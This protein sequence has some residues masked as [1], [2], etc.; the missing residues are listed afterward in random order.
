VPVV[1][2]AQILAVLDE[3]HDPAT[4]ES[5]DAVGL[6]CGDPADDVSAILLA[7]DP[8]AA[9]AQEAQSLG[10]QL[11][12]T[13]H[14][15]LLSGVHSVATTSPKGALLHQLIRQ[16][17]ALHVAHTNADAANPGVSDALAR[18]LGL[19]DLRPLDPLPRPAMDRLG[20][21][22]PTEHAEALLDALAAAGAGALGNYDRAAW[23]VEGTGTFRPLPGAHP[24]FGQ[25]GRIERVRETR[26][27]LQLPRTARSRV[28]SALH[29][30]HPYETPA[31]DLV[32][33]VAESSMLGIGRIGRLPE[34]TTLREFVARAATALPATSW[35]VRAAGDPDRMI[36]S[37]ACCGGAGGTYID[38]ARAAGAD[39]YLTSDLR[40][41][42][43]SEAMDPTLSTATS[44][45]ALVDAAHWA[46]EA[47]WLD[48]LGA[49]LRAH[50]GTS[51]SVSV[52][53]IV[54]DPWTLH[55]PSDS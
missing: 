8:V 20:V 22:V 5:W 53:G 19:T 38:A 3:W 32:E 34:P 26:L 16:G 37:V 10:A 14:P 23:S 24:A 12:V 44:P 17:R 31:F 30:Q 21:F 4:A 54:T 29:A 13:H 25:V 36:D 55:R 43:A 46:T 39:V 18:R 9:V 28:L 51:V 52:S 40:H 49:R 41:H 11:I 35:G 1:Q 6:V 42:V 50:F 48:E 47:P 27:D 15:L 7:V 2:L 45:M 33:Q